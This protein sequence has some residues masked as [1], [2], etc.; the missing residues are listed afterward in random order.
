MN[1]LYSNILPLGVEENQETVS[2][3]FSNEIASSDAV[4]I[5]VG[6]VSK[7]SLEE[8]DRIVAAK[9]IQH[10]KLTI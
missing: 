1:L 6:Y 4:E 2:D 8:L 9:D 10:I 3:C 5:A 7:A